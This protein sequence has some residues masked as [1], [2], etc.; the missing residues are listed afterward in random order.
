MHHRHGDQR[1]IHHRTHRLRRAVGVVGEAAGGLQALVA[2]HLD[3][4]QDLHLL[5]LHALDDEEQRVEPQVRRLHTQL[6]AAL[7]HCMAVGHTLVIVLGDA[8]GRAQGDDNGVVIRGQVDV[9]NSGTGVGRVDNGL[10]V[11]PVID[12]DARLN[13]PLVGRIQG[14]RDVIEVLLQQLDKR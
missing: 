13:S 11:G 8:V 4:L 7:E 3:G 12:A 2:E 6:Q 9:G 10:A 14:Q 1:R 5:V